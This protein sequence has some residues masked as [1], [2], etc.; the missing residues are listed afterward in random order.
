[1]LSLEFRVFVS[2]R[3]VVIR[4][5][6]Y[7]LLF[8]VALLVFEDVTMLLGVAFALFSLYYF[9]INKNNLL[10]FLILF[11]TLKGVL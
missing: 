9:S 3:V 10:L 5:L 7:L 6:L 1:M 2:E 11:V 4:A 8:S